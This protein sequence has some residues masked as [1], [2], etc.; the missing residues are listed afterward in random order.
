MFAVEFRVVVIIPGIGIFIVGIPIGIPSGVASAISV[1][2]VV[3]IVGAI[4]MHGCA[5]REGLLTFHEM[6]DRL[7]GDGDIVQW[8]SVGYVRESPFFRKR[9]VEQNFAITSGS[10]VI[11]A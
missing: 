4:A 3:A 9:V 11:S 2:I 6:N 1:G 7:Y 8:S 5:T 10:V